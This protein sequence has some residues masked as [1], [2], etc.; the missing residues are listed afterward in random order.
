MV[1]S[2]YWRDV[3]FYTALSKGCMST[4]AD[5]WLFNGTLYVRDI[6]ILANDGKCA[7]LVQVGHDESSLSKDRTLESLYINPM[8]DVLKRQNPESQFAS[9]PTRQ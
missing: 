7:E 6:P 4:E 2:D 5:V 8:L 1:F 3:P 9:N